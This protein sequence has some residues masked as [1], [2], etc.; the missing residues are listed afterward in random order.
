LEVL[1]KVLSIG[2]GSTHPPKGFVMGLMS[3]DKDGEQALFTDI[4]VT[5][6][7]DVMLVLLIIFMVTAPFMIETI[8]V[9]LPQGEGAK[10]EGLTAP[11]TI[12][13]DKNENIMIAGQQFSIDELK[14]FLSE[15]P[16]IKNNEPIFIEADE[17]VRHKMVMAVMSS[18]YLAGAHKVNIMMEKP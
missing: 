2:R 17:T 4:N 14:T 16:R 8:G 11:L 3:F 12:S 10:A 9:D 7:V 13:I 1:P 5:P 6:L 15:S 18:A